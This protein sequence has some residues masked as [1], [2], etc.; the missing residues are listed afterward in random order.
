MPRQRGKIGQAWSIN[1]GYLL[2]L[3]VLRGHG[4]TRRVR[5]KVR[6][7]R[8]L[9]AAAHQARRTH[10]GET[11]NHPFTNG[12]TEGIQRIKHRTLGYRD[13]ESFGAAILFRF[14]SLT[15]PRQ[16][17]KSRSFKPL[18]E[19]Y[20]RVHLVGRGVNEPVG[21]S[22]AQSCLILLDDPYLEELSRFRYDHSD[23]GSLRRGEHDLPGT[24]PCAGD[25]H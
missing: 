9:E 7:G 25:Y 5:Q 19:D 3:A 18:S 11:R 14:G 15:S 2:H 17:P 12:R 24:R 21:E 4:S 20:Q 10:G 13:R 16:T 23:I 8:S 1:D 22:G 6:L